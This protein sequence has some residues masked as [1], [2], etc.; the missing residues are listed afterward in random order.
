MSLRRK[1]LLI[2]GITLV[3]LLGVLSISLTAIQTISFQRVEQQTTQVNVQRVLDAYTDEV[4]KLTA[5]AGDWAAWDDSYQFIG[6]GND[7]YIQ[8]TLTDAT[9]LRVNL[10]LIAYVR[11]DGQVLFSR[12][13]DLAH[14]APVAM[15]KAFL[16]QLTPNSPL[17]AH[18]TTTDGHAGLIM[19]PE[20]PLVVA[21]RP[22]VRSDGS[23]PPRG[24]LIMA[25]FL[26]TPAIDALAQRT[27]FAVRA[28]PLHQEH[29][30]SLQLVSQTLTA[31]PD[32]IVSQAQN[33]QTMTGYTILPDVYGQP[34][35]V[36]AVDFTRVVHQQGVLSLLYT[37]GSLLVT[38]VVF[39][40]VTVL[41]LQRLVLTPV[42]RL[43]QGVGAI[44]A[45]RDRTGR[46]PVQGAD[47]LA[48][49][50]RSINGM[51]DAISQAQDGWKESEDR[52]RAVVEHASE[53]IVLV[54][55]RTFTV[56]QTNAAFQHLLGFS[57]DRLLGCSFQQLIVD[58]DYL[59]THDLPTIRAHGKAVLG[60][61]LYRCADNTV[62]PV[63]VGA[64]VLMSGGNE[65]TCFVVHDLTERKRAEEERAR[66]HSER[67]FRALVQNA[68]DIILITEP[69]GTIRY[70]SPAV[71][72]TW[73]YEAQA[74]V[75]TSSI[76][77][78]HP[79]DQ[80]TLQVLLA[81]TLDKPGVNLTSEVRIAR[82][83]GTWRH[84]EII[85]NNLLDDVEVHGISATLRDITE[86]K[87]FETDLSHLAF[88]DALT[89]LPNRSLFMVR[90]EQALAH[91]ERH[92]TQV[93]LIFLDL[94][95]FK[96]IN[97]SLGHQIGD[98][99]LI[100]VA[101]RIQRC[102]RPQDMAARLGGDEFTIVLEDITD[103]MDATKV[104]ERIIQELDAAFALDAH[105]VFTSTSIGIA[106]SSTDNQDP[107]ALLRDADLAM[108][109][110]KTG[111]KGRYEIF[112]R[113]MN[114]QILRRLELETAMRRAIDRQ[115]FEVFYQPVVQLATERIV[116]VEALIRWNH[117]QKGMIP[118]AEFIPVAEE[119]GLILAIGHWVLTEA[120]H[121]G[122]AWHLAFPDEPALI[123][124]VNLSMRQFQNPHLVEDIMA[125]LTD[126]GFPAS[127]LKLEITESIMMQDTRA[128]ITTMTQL[129][130]LGI[131]LAIDDF[132]TGYSSLG[133]L[134]RLPIDTLKIDRSFID[135]LG[136]DLGDT[137]IVETITTLAKTLRL[138]V[139]GEGIETDVQYMHLRD[140]GCDRGQGYYFAKPLSVA[141]L[142]AALQSGVTQLILDRST[143]SHEHVPV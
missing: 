22:I 30:A 58:A 127:C 63:E 133:Y 48:L 49:L 110:A 15:P 132:G 19:L 94:D 115:E 27:H 32:Q 55:M 23:G 76:A 103:V 13:L 79:D 104:A 83:D 134:K 131:R 107:N 73:G 5:Q 81:Q 84:S 40:L 72:R 2:V 136:M 46:L 26:D 140:L 135:Q 138:S 3:A 91:A 129:R 142:G 71:E 10:N 25:R 97:D 96:L 44:A 9:L 43:S 112:D 77:L 139:T 18:R 37:S 31:Y 8:A 59:I 45:S 87:Q 6:D 98:C 114:T 80:P 117:P 66:R 141:D 41:L 75:G 12:A 38:S 124:S 99:L 33:S 65:V 90:L 89:S 123:M 39:G 28:V 93:A 21:A 42:A 101:E 82:A 67:H 113:S 7:T 14:A 95:N 52:Y 122:R 143:V 36:L 121:Q 74:L 20:G 86:R 56:T 100:A 116:E 64:S 109:R 24:T 50:G 119:T 51:L 125:V 88:H 61:R 118:P 92:A 130:D 60:E 34:A 4:A 16:D 78:V 69:D 17:L 68:T 106:L 120:C 85:V 53:G 57:A 137:A 11:P 105:E 29:P 62:L 126:T 1:T 102:I 128:T 111:G 54:D 70:Q 35:L 108:Y 47:E